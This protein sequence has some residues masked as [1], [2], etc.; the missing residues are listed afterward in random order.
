M[1]VSSSNFGVL[2]EP[3]L[4]KVFYE[5]Y[6][7]LPEQFP[8]V[9]K[10][11]T[12]KK[13]KE[14]DQHVAGLGEW[15]EKESMGSISYEA[16][17][18]GD[19]VVYTH[20]EYAKGCQVE[21]KLVDDE[22]YSVIKKLPK[23][24][25]KGGRVKVEKNA[26]DVL[27]NGF[28]NT[29]YDGVAL[30]SDS[31]PLR[32][33][34]GGTC[35]NLA[36]GALNEVNLQAALLLARRQVDDAGLKIQCMPKKLIIPADLEFKATVLLQSSNQV[37]SANN[38]INSVKGKLRM[39]I[40]DYLTSATAWFLQDDSFDNLIFWHRIRPEFNRET[41]FDTHIQKYSGYMRSSQGYS[42]WR[43]LVASTGL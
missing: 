17:N 2:L 4:R 28:T 3:G 14:T 19:D 21:R 26:A 30:F 25:G 22:M 24:L 8:Q 1:A 33:N 41:N 15:E 42:S 32:G 43:G 12:S 31:H 10:V 39:V 38:N 23:S 27:N 37:D 36:S 34:S 16:I 6:T 7:E 20:T 9:F 18:L 29:G 13:A 11:M 40:M 5:S 35:D